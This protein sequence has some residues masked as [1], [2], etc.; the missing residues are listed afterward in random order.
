MEAP[1]ESPKLGTK[2]GTT[3]KSLI[4]DWTEISWIFSENFYL[5][6]DPSIFQSVSRLS[7]NQLKIITTN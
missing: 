1:S 3:I 5:S 2:L 4:Y 6:I 7:E